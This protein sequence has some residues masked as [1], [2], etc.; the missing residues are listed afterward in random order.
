MIGGHLS[1]QMRDQRLRLQSIA[2][3]D[4]VTGLY[5]RAHFE[6]R[7]ASESARAARGHRLFSLVLLD[8]PAFTTALADDGYAIGD[9]LLRRVA[10]QVDSALP[11]TLR[12]LGAISA[13][14]GGGTFALLLPEATHAEGAEAA[15]RI[16]AAVQTAGALAQAERVRARVEQIRLDNHDLRLRAGIAT[17]GEHGVSGEELVRAAQRALIQA[18]ES[19]PVQVSTHHAADIRWQTKAGGAQ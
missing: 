5:R 12:H 9:M 11:D 15:E 18:P 3:R 2:E 4:P 13:H 1:Q 19:D 16:R 8:V 7:L 17:Y 14:Y 10:A 6:R